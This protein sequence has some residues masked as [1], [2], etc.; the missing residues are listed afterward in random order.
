MENDTNPGKYTAIND[1]SHPAND[2]S[3]PVGT[4]DIMNKKRQ[5]KRLAVTCILILLFAAGLVINEAD[6]MGEGHT[7]ALQ[8]LEVY[9]AF[10]PLLIYIVPFGI[11]M[12][13]IRT[14]YEME[15]SELLTA[16]FCGAFIPAAFAGELNGGFDDLM[17]SLMGSS[18]SDSWIGSAEAG[19]AEELLKLA[20]TA[21]LLYVLN[22][23]SLEHYLIIGMC[24]G[25]GFQI[26]E[27]ISY[28]TQTG[29]ENVNDA[30][31]T[32]LD[33]ISGALGSHWAY[34]AVTAA[35]LYLIVQAC[36]RNHGRKGICWILF[37]MTDHFLYD[38]PLG[39][40]LLINAVLTAAVV[41]PVVIFFKSTATS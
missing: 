21:I 6:F 19:V 25:M 13:R 18:Y 40:A 10:L 27:D 5:R 34:A 31:P 33:R 32:A 3:H 12:K 1:Y 16:V 36:S 30:F 9:S 38:S 29:F 26:E 39:T 8:Y 17:N 15:R 7:T 35:G 41:L 14:K 22:R 11:I 37:V 23:K 28:I 4:P 24:V 2:H 20:T